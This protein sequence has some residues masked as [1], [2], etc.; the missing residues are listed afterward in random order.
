MQGFFKQV[1][2]MFSFQCLISNQITMI[3]EHR[4]LN[5]D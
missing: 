2:K 5:I 3:N 1:Y 4:I